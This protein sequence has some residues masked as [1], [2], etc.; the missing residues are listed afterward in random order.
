MYAVIFQGTGR[1]I[2]LTL[3]HT[4]MGLS[5][6]ESGWNRLIEAIRAEDPCAPHE[7]Q[8]TLSLALRLAPSD[9][10]VSN[11]EPT[12]TTKLMELTGPHY[13]SGGAVVFERGSS[14]IYVLVPEE[15]K[16]LRVIAI[17]HQDDL[18]VLAREIS[19]STV[20]RPFR[21]IPMGES[22]LNVE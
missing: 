17:V 15:A 14:R 16:A 19:C 7:R 20:R 8:E 10:R 2:A 22:A 21:C 5:S 11:V 12:V 6:S 1:Q 9:C 4:S 13:E 3:P 18:T